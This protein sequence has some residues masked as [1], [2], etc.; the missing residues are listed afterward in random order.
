[1]S[2]E[3]RPAG[4]VLPALPPAGIAGGWLK[5]YSECRQYELV[6]GQKFTALVGQTSV[7]SFTTAAGFFTLAER[8]GAV[9]P[10]NLWLAVPSVVGLPM[11]A[12]LIV[13]YFLQ[14]RH[15][16]G[17]MF[18]IEAKMLGEHAST[19][20]LIHVL[21]SPPTVF[22]GSQWTLALVCV[23]VLIL[24]LLPLAAVRALL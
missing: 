22:Y 16:D 7:F 19:L 17:I 9:Y 11:Y 8:L 13:K 5:Y 3:N 24:V 18:D 15:T 21:R 4:E 1:M 14:I 2:E 20:G 12:V 10:R 6:M 23:Y